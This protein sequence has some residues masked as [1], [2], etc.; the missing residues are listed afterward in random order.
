MEYNTHGKFYGADV[1][2]KN[3]L[4]N[5]QDLIEDLTKACNLNIVAETRKN[6][7]PGETIVL[8]LS[9]SHLAIHTYPE[10]KYFSLDIYTC[11][12]EGNPAAAKEF[13]K[14]NADKLQIKRLSDFTFERG[15]TTGTSDPIN[16]I[17]NF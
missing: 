2:F 10:H 15:K 5:M 6:F 1:W 9:E 3:D 13:F 7:K 4:P 12:Q 17:S 11:G 16:G 14:K 8:I